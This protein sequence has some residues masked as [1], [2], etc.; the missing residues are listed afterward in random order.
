MEKEGFHALWRSYKVTLLMNIPFSAA[1]ISVNENL[2]TLSNPADHKYTY[3]MYF[4][5]AFI[6]GSVAAVLTN[7]LDVTKT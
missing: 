2:K 6:A 4:G 1:L 7:P 5:C 3:S